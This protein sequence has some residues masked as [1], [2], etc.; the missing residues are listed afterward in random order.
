MNTNFAKVRE[1]FLAIAATD[2]AHERERLDKEIGRIEQELRTVEAK[3]Q[4]QAFVQRAP[5]AVVQEH[6][7]RLTDFSAQLERL[8]QAREA[9]N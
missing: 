3:L 5:A 9:L 7:R 1:I 4:N 2:Q 6:R 8:Q